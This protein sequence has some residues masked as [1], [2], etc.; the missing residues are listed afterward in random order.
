MLI[1]T[2]DDK[3]YSDVSAI[4]VGHLV[5]DLVLVTLPIGKRPPDYTVIECGKCGVDWTVLHVKWA[6]SI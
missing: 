4:G 6:D 2:V 3:P 1:V 5:K